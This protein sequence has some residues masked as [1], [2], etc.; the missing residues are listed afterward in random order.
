M[1]FDKYTGPTFYNDSIPILPVTASFQKS[2][3]NCS[4]KQ[5][6]LMLGYA[7]SIHRSQGITLDKAVVNL[8]EK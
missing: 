5:F 1:S 4:R 2:G 6:L 7:I 8:G 3:V